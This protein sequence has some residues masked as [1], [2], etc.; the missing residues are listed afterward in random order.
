MRN[1]KKKNVKI[2]DNHFY[3]RLGRTETLLSLSLLP[4][5]QDRFEKI[6]LFEC[7]LNLRPDSYRVAGFFRNATQTTAKAIRSSTSTPSLTTTWPVLEVCPLT[8]I[9]VAVTIIDNTPLPLP[10]SF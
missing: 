5:R 10:Q 9:A 3:Y 1:L 8:M 4:H 7:P 2:L 6:E